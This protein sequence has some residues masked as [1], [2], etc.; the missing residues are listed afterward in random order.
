[1]QRIKEK[2]YV[3][4]NDFAAGTD[5]EAIQRAVAEA[6]RQ[7]IRRVV[8][9]ANN[10]RTG[11]DYW[12]LDGPIFLP[13]EITVILDGALIR[14]KGVAF[15][16]EAVDD[17]NG[18]CMGREQRNIFLIGQHGGRIEGLRNSPQIRLFNVYKY[19]VD[20]ITFCGGG[21]VQLEFTRNGKLLHLQFRDSL[22]GISLFEGNRNLIVENIAGTTFQEFILVRGGNGTLLGR[23]PD[24]REIILCRM[25]AQT[26]GTPAVGL[27]A[28]SIKICNLVVRDLTD[29]TSGGVS[30]CVGNVSDPG[31]I[32][33]VTIRGVSSRRCAVETVVACDGMYYTSLHTPDGIPK[34]VQR[35]ENTRELLDND[36]TE[37]ILP[38]FSEL[39][40]DTPFL[41]PN[42]PEFWAQSDAQTIMNTIA[43]AS[44]R[45]I[46]HVV[47]PRWNMRANQPRW[48]IDETIS[49]PSDMTVELWGC[50]LRLADFCYCNMFSNSNA[51]MTEE[52]TSASEQKNIRIT[53]VGDAVLD[54]GNHNGLL[55]KTA[56]KN[57]LPHIVHNVMVLFINV[58][59]VVV[60]NI[61]IC[62][63]RFYGCSF[64][65]CDHGRVS[66]ID[67][68]SREL[69]PNL[70]GVDLRTGTQH[71][72]V[73][74][75]T[76][77]TSDDAVAM[78][79]LSGDCLYNRGVVDKAPASHHILVRNVMA[80]P[81]RWYVVRLLLHDGHTLQ[82]VV[83][84]TVIDASLTEFKKRPQACFNIGFPEYI[85]VRETELGELARITVRDLYSRSDCMIE[86]GSRVKDLHI[87]NGHAHGDGIPAMVTVRIRT[88]VENLYAK[89]LFYR[90]E[91]KSLYLTQ[92]DKSN[93]TKPTY[94]GTLFNLQHFQA[95]N[96]VFEDIFADKCQNIAFM[97]GGGRIDIR[98]LSVN[99]YSCTYAESGPDCELNINGVQSPRVKTVVLPLSANEKDS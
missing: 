80:D 79:N 64:Y 23:D 7:E 39:S 28:G 53:G 70:D 25:Q 35:K 5:Q 20:G 24:I 46:N 99:E 60:E 32:R 94:K 54:G 17:P 11:N 21:G 43:A 91:Q 13:S 81:A 98:N 88:E 76:G 78:N 38:Q 87:R 52:R 71:F 37:I 18:R 59:G 14:S 92:P 62:R 58:S 19:R 27:Y 26:S 30:V 31:E 55:E 36:E 10:E 97:T 69:V 95:K 3:T 4:P 84:D 61:H 90:P 42:Q 63:Q 49:L 66:N 41:T 34:L 48:D 29:N 96:V 47:I 83:V 75:I 57:G 2:L 16:N 33:D 6:V 56:N 40:I 68:Y 93:S 45:G 86:I 85:R 74:N 12:E 65:F 44:E 1:M 82:D 50:H 72:L 8:I 89:G 15:Q 22:Y 77:T 73:E 9:P 67:F 51:Y